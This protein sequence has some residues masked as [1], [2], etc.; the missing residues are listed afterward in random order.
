VP[1]KKLCG[2]AFL[3]KGI[4]MAGYL[5]ILIAVLTEYKGGAVAPSF[6]PIIFADEKSCK[7][8]GEQAV[9][10]LPS[11]QARCIRVTNITSAAPVSQQ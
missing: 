1:A 8:A 2:T 7:V 10:G 3:M 6:A 4:F 11:I 5:L 9:R